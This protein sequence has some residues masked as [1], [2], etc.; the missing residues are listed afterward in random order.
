[1]CELP[2]R[3]KF[4]GIYLIKSFNQKHNTNNSQIS[5]RSAKMLQSLKDDLKPIM[6]KSHN[7]IKN[8]PQTPSTNPNGIFSNH[9][10]SSL[11]SDPTKDTGITSSKDFNSVLSSF[12]GKLPS[13]E[14]ISHS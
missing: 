6:I 7:V 3:N 4:N 5:N 11:T 14:N 10:I 8:E 1:M 13:S 12:L 2:L 9:H